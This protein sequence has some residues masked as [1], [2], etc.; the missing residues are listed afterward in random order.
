ML[1][2]VI[3]IMNANTLETTQSTQFT[4]N[5]LTLIN[6]N[7]VWLI[8]EI[9]QQQQRLTLGPNSARSVDRAHIHIHIPS[10]SL[11][12]FFS[13]SWSYNFCAVIL[14]LPPMI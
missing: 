7:L 11:S 9:K 3:F 12:F 4:R 10:H 5:V 1:Y 8:G 6:L 14:L 13:F 2:G